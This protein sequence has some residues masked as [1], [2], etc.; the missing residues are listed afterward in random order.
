MVQR[1]TRCAQRRIG[2]PLRL[3]PAPAERTCTALS[4]CSIC[5]SFPDGQKV[6]SE[7]ALACSAMVE[8]ATTQE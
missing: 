5:C 6:V 1:D 2:A 7:K 8:G 3:Q 4:A